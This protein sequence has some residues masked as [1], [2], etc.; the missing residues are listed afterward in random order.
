MTLG[1]ALNRATRRINSLAE[2]MLAQYD[3]SLPQWLVLTA[4][5]RGD[6]LTIS[7]LASY[8]DNGQPALSRLLDRMEEK[9]LVKRSPAPDDRRVVC[10]C[11][12]EK[13]RA[14]RPL[15]TIYE[16]FHDIMMRRLDSAERATLLKLLNKL[17]IDEKKKK[18]KKKKNGH[19][20]D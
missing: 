19:A 11:L 1:R 8:C 17:T 6:G 3:L 4:L 5:W 20:P 15:L 7:Q 10:I 12:T 16:E 14:M 9:G 13:S 18:K 2:T